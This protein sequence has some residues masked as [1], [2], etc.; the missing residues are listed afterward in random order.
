MWNTAVS[1]GNK[2]RTPSCSTFWEW[3]R[4]P[5]RWG[6]EGVVGCGGRKAKDPGGMPPFGGPVWACWCG[7]GMVWLNW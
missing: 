6:G 2:A 7:L 5:G 3:K 4:P 1:R